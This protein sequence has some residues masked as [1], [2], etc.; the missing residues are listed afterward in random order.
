MITTVPRG[1][2][3]RFDTPGGNTTT[4]LA[5]PQLGAKELLV[6]HQTQLPGGTSPMHVK[7]TEALVVVLVGNVDVVSATDT[8]SLGEGDAALISL[9]RRTSCGVRVTPPAQWLFDYPGE[10]RVQNAE[11]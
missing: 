11:R 4:A 8:S 6:V 7:T 5:S 9:T 3:T 10:R 1:Q 2:S